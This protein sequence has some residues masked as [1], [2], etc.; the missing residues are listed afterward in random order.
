MFFIVQRNLARAY[1]NLPEEKK[2]IPETNQAEKIFPVASLVLGGA[3]AFVFLAVFAICFLLSAELMIASVW[4]NLFASLGIVSGILA[5]A[6][7]V[8]GLFYGFRQRWL[9]IIGT[10]AGVASVFLLYY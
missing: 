2:P 7:G 10:L 4:L 8:T 1:S 9:L 3:S 5:A 6:A